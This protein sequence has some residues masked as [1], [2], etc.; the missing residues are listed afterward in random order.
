MRSS[1][2][3]PSGKL[4][5]RLP[6]PVQRFVAS[7][8]APPN[9]TFRIAV[10]TTTYGWVLRQANLGAPLSLHGRAPLEILP[11]QSAPRR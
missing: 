4:R 1:T 8:W 7:Q 5:M 6:H 3:G 9:T 11:G 10:F 2:E